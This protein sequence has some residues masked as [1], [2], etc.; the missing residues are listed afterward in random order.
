MGFWDSVKN[1]AIKAKC[2]VGIHAGEYTHISGK[3]LCHVEK[4][5]PDCNKYI[6][7]IHHNFSEPE[8]ENPISCVQIAHCIHCNE[9]KRKTVHEA[10]ERLGYDK[11][12]S[13]R[14]TEQCVRCRHTRKGDEHHSWHRL[15][16]QY[17]NS[18]YTLEC[19]DCGKKETRNA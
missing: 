7:N 9:E 14:A 13:C 1:A 11:D 16:S 5:C 10:Y 12:G 6:S 17:G 18:A 8:Y 19:I 2:T 4:T 3:P 15:P